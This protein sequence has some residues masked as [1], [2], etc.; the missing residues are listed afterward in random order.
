MTRSQVTS[1]RCRRCGRRGRVRYPAD[2][3]DAVR[4]GRLIRADHAARAPH[5]PLQLTGVELISAAT[6]TATEEDQCH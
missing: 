1:W 5:C 3:A 6:E 4:V 2:G